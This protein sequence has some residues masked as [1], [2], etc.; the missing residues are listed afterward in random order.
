MVFI[1]F[2]FKCEWLSGYYDIIFLV[3]D[4]TFIWSLLNVYVCVLLFCK[5]KCQKDQLHHH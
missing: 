2:L 4:I 5:I 1:Y 3:I